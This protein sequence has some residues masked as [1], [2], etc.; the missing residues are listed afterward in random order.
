MSS[1]R[2]A[3]LADLV[4]MKLVCEICELPFKTFT[5]IKVDH[6]HRTDKARGLLCQNC[7]LALGMLRDNPR[8]FHRAQ[9][10]LNGRK[11][12]LGNTQTD[13]AER[14]EHIQRKRNRVWQSRS[15][16]YVNA[17]EVATLLRLSI[18]DVHKLIRVSSSFPRPSSHWI[19]GSLMEW[20]ESHEGELDHYRQQCERA[21]AQIASQTQG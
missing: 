14:Q 1:R 17:S 19:R 9:L 15:E 4:E 7:N 11:T 8:F 10:Y 20:L 16:R 18:G 21:R 2:I 6:D 3:L 13:A 12:K 5:D